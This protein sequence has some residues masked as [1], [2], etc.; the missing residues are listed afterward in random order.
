VNVDEYLKEIKKKRYIHIYIYIYIYIYVSTYIYLH[1]Y[2]IYIYI[3]I[4]IYIYIYRFSV[5]PVIGTVLV[6]H[7]IDLGSR[8]YRLCCVLRYVSPPKLNGHIPEVMI[9]VYDGYQERNV[10]I[11][12]CQSLGAG[13][14][15]DTALILLHTS[16]HK[17]P[18]NKNWID[19]I[20][21]EHTE[22][23]APWYVYIYI[24]MHTCMYKYLYRYIYIYVYMYIYTYVYMYVYIYIYICM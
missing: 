22:D 19:E 11:S 14:Y 6:V 5:L 12:C 4:H 3:Y 21:D 16:N 24:Y 13:G 1:T 8:V 23:M 10:S 7:L 9:R 17:T 18:K 15:I 20:D 2:V